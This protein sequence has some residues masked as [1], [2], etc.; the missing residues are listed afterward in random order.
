MSQEDGKRQVK[1]KILE[2]DDMGIVIGV[3]QL[4]EVDGELMPVGNWLY[5]LKS[6]ERGDP[7]QEIT[8]YTTEPI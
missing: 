8:P 1:L 6:G 2:S 3:D 4:S 5:N 7:S